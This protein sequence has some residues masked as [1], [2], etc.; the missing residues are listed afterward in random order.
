MRIVTGHERRP[1][2]TTVGSLAVGTSETRPAGGNTVNI[3]CLADLVPV[4]GKGR[5][6]QVV[7]DNEQHVHFPGFCCL[8]GKRHA[9]WP[10]EGGNHNRWYQAGHGGLP[11]QKWS[12]RHPLLPAN[13]GFCRVLFSQSLPVILPVLVVIVIGSVLD[14][15]RVDDLRRRGRII[16]CQVVLAGPPAW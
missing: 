14:M 7:R 6:S 3:R 12:R 16:S 5:G 11:L 13:T 4:T 2:G 8:S 15:N 10:Q 9:D 1:R